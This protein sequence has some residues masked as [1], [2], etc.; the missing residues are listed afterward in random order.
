[1]TIASPRDKIVQECVRLV[2]EAIFEPTFSENSHGFRLG[3]S[4]HTALKQIKQ[5][6]DSS[7]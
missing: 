7:T 3:R 4:C 5:N 1:L 2:L 6:F